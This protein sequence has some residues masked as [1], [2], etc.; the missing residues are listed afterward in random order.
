MCDLLAIPVLQAAEHLGLRVPADLSVIGFDG[1]PLA[2][3]VR[4]ALTTIQQPLVEKGVI[5][6]ELLLSDR[7]KTPACVLDTQLIVRESTGA[8]PQPSS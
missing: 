2:A 5:A 6:A 8:A 3:Q 1:I 4:P 7:D